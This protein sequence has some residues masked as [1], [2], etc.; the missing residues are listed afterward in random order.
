MKDQMHKFLYNPPLSEEVYVS[1]GSNILESQTA[2]R[3]NYE[4]IDMFDD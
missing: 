2:T 4:A 3:E 1:A